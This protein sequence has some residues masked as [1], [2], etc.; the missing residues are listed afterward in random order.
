MKE[1]LLIII[2]R[3]NNDW[4]LLLKFQEVLGC[5]DV[6]LVGAKAPQAY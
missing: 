1:N 2:I 5:G 4:G 3:M 6:P